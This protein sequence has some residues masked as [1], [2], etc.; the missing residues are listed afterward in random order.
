M[1]EMSLNQAIERGRFFEFKQAVLG[2][3]R[4]VLFFL[5]HI[6]DA[7]SKR[8]LTLLLKAEV[9]HAEGNKLLEQWNA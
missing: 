3:S 8:N 7:Y 9:N 4:R 5:A 2:L 6:K 1:C